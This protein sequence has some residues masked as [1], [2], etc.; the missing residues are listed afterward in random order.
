MSELWVASGKGELALVPDGLLASIGDG[1]VRRRRITGVAAPE[2]KFD[3]NIVESRLEDIKFTKID[4][5]RCDWKDCRIERATFVDCDMGHAAMLTNAFWECRFARCRFPDT[6]VSDCSFTV[7]AFEDCDFTSIIVKSSR[8]EKCQF[9]N[10]TT[11][12]RLIE[13]SLLIR[14]T[15]RDMELAVALI[16]GNFGLRNSELTK[17]RIVSRI[18]NRE[19]IS[20]SIAV[21]APHLGPIERFRL[22]YFWTEEID[23]DAVALEEALDLRKWNNDAVVQTSFGAQLSSFSQ[24]LLALYNLNEIPIYPLL[25]LH[26]RNFAFLEWLSSRDDLILLYPVVAGIHL[27]LTREIDAFVSQLSLLLS[28]LGDVRPI[29]FAAEGPL[30]TAYFE[31]W[32]AEQGLPGVQVVSARPRNSP[33]AL[34]AVFTD[35]GYYIGAIALFLACRTKFELMKITSASENGPPVPAPSGQLLVAFSAGFSKARPAEYE[36]NVQTIL[37]R[38]LLLDLHLSLS[39]A[40]F[41]RARGVLVGLIMP[42]TGDVVP[43]LAPAPKAVRSR[44]RSPPK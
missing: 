4:F 1:D 14:T 3:Y 36:I 37:P 35:N 29:H 34:A 17:C 43:Q 31:R 25:V 44:R 30:D 5:D 16:I 10:C 15:W 9:S 8:F 6:G 7:C 2:Q 21:A 42:S 28:I 11:S 22:A 32:F 40:I 23:G 12:N 39:V 38:S 26:S 18:G 24:F 41:K 27:T 13:S 33:I 20:Q 19:P